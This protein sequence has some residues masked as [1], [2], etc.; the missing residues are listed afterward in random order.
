M[1]IVI[2][3]S[4]YSGEVLEHLLVRATTGNEMVRGGH[5]RLVPNISDKFS[6]PRLKA[7]RMLQKRKEQ[8]KSV[9]SKGNFTYDEKELKP[10]E[11]MAY[12][13]FNPRSFE[14]V[15]RRFQPKGALV[16]SEL[17]SYAQNLLLSELAKEVDFEVGEHF[18]IGKAG[19]GADQFFN[20]IL[21]RAENDAD[22]VK[23]E[24]PIAIDE[25]NVIAT[26][27]TIAG[28]VPKAIRKHPD[29]KMFMSHE[30][31]EIYD[32]VITASTKGKGHDEYNKAKYKGIK[33]VPLAS[34]PKNTIVCCI[35]SSKM[36]TNL[37]AG[38]GLVD[39]AEAVL[40]DK[41]SN[42]GELYFF[43]MLMKADTEIAFGEDLVFYQYKA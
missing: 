11:F 1:A 28:K 41:V 25:S 24:N 42:A 18:V 30:D 23:I 14:T 43:K 26:F 40:I 5:I 17:S 29:L 19:D 3:G 12:T 27:K 35:G 31:Y 32:D 39:D 15:W 9:D 20:G 33:I 7:G 6:I 8:P 37:W 22:T 13:E 36:S 16:F 4:N 21:Y 34:M 10:L 2:A 38:V